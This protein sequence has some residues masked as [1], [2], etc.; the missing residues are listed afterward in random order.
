MPFC[1]STSCM[2]PTIA[3]FELSA[4]FPPFSM[5]VLPLFRHR[6][7]MSKLTLGRASYT[8]PIT[9]NGTLILRRRSPLGIVRS[10]STLPVGEGRAATSR[11]PSAMSSSLFPVS[12]SLSNTGLPLSARSRSLAFAFSRES[13][14]AVMASAR[15]VSMAFLRSSPMSVRHRLA[16]FTLLNNSVSS[17]V[18][19]F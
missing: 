6:A 7:N 12:L 3:L 1:L 8:A 5:Q 10:M 18:M 13:F 14:P 9:P 19:C 4:S 17:T 16:S 15:L 11:M 2:S